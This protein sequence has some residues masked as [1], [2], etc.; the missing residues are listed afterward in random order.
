MN[1]E[2]IE[3]PEG[4]ERSALKD[5]RG[6]I[7]HLD[8]EI[9]IWLG[10]D[11]SECPVDQAWVALKTAREACLLLLAGQ[12]SEISLEEDLT[13]PDL[14]PALPV[15]FGRGSEVIGFVEGRRSDGAFDGLLITER[16]NETEAAGYGEILDVV[17]D[18]IPLD[19]PIKVWLDDEREAYEGWKH[20]RTAREASLLSLLADVEELSLDNDLGGP[21]TQIPGLDV[22]LVYGRGEEVGEFLVE[23][24]HQ[25]R[26]SFPSKTLTVHSANNVAGENL[27]RA[28]QG[29]ERYGLNLTL[30]AKGAKRYF[31]FDK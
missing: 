27:Q 19:K 8:R 1:S 23:A 3:L 20:L 21:E 29:L 9:R 22:N 28:I 24:F 14:N 7:I 25:G 4:Y 16:S 12:V 17:G 5:A 11:P 18:P 2:E 6:N 31:H 10:K 15:Q 13:G 30:E 26:P